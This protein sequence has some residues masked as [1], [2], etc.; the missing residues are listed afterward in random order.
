MIE[1]CER[2]IS[3]LEFFSAGEGE[4][5]SDLHYESSARV[6]ILRARSPPLFNWLDGSPFFV[7]FLGSRLGVVER[8][9]YMPFATRQFPNLCQ[10]YIAV[11]LAIKG[12]MKSPCLA[13][14]LR[15]ICI[16][17]VR[18]GNFPIAMA[19]IVDI[20]RTTSQKSRWSRMPY[21]PLL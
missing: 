11:F 21:S 6:N 4:P 5:P 15:Y 17:L 16:L 20:R 18:N 10:H 7:S 13:M 1:Q 12:E 3:E 14:G 19:F 8:G 9:A 2:G